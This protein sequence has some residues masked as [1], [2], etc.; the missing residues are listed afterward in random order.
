MMIDIKTPNNA[1]LFAMQSRGEGVLLK[2]DQVTLQ[3]AVTL[4]ELGA[5]KLES[6]YWLTRGAAVALQKRSDS[7]ALHQWLSQNDYVWQVGS[8]TLHDVSGVIYGVLNV[9]PES[10]YNGEL[11]SKKVDTMVSRAGEMLTL[12][13]DVIEIGGQTTKPGYVELT[14]TEE[15]NRISP[16]IKG[17]KQRFPEAIVAVDTYKYEVM[18][19]AVALGVNIINDVNGFLDD[20]RK[21]PFL[22]NKQVGLLTMWNPRTQAVTH[23][24]QEMH[25]WFAENLTALTAYG[26]DR[27]RI[28]LDP[29]VGYAKNS[30]GHQDLAMMNTIA[31]LQDFRRP[32]MTAVANKGWA[33]FLLDLPKNKRADV[34]LIAANEMF[35]RGA[36]ILRVH[37]VQSAKQMVQVVQAISGSFLTS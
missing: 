34:S 13:A 27:E 17:I 3:F 25:D 14:A 21:G 35:R 20:E 18:V 15:I 30:N 1:V 24:Q 6:N 33:K 36:R 28:A 32:I 23:L 26:I 37:D 29:G 12:G 4:S 10:F 7:Y 11:V 22:A 19:M 9:S 5:V 2:F 31:H 16:V 8:H